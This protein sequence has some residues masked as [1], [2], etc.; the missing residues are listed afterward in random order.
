MV[1]ARDVRSL[2]GRV[3]WFNLA[4]LAITPAVGVYGAY[5]TRLRFET[6]IWSVTYYVISML[7]K[8]THRLALGTMELTTYRYYRW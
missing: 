8:Y 3:R 5:T 7:G 4:I 6:L 1:C 2:L